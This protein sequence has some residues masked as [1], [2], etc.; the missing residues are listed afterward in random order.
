MLIIHQIFSLAHDW[1]KRVTLL[2]AS[3]GENILQRR[4]K[5]NNR[6]F[7]ITAFFRVFDVTA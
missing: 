7:G 2:D 1:S 6:R 5:K 3:K 4:Y